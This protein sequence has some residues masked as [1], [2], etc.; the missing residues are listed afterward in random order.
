M[1][2]LASLTKAT[3]RTGT[4]ILSCSPSESLEFNT[5]AAVT[6]NLPCFTFPRGLKDLSAAA[7]ESSRSMEIFF[8]GWKAHDQSKKS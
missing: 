5:T 3:A 8:L 2:G 6:P 7:V 1:L 4:T